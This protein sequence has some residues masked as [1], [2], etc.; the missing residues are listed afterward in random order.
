M[1]QPLAALEAKMAGTDL[2]GCS[3]AELRA[4][5]AEADAGLRV[6][7]GYQARI[8][9]AA[10]QLE[11]QGRGS[12]AEDTMRTGTVS[13][14]M[15]RRLADRAAIG[16]LLPAVGA[17]LAAGA[18]RPENVD[19]LAAKTRHLSDRERRRLVDRDAVLARQSARLAPDTFSRVVAK[20]VRAARDPE[21]EGLSVVE[22]QA[23]RSRFDM[24]RAFDGMWDLR[25][26]LDDERGQQLNDWINQHAPA[27]RPTSDH[28]SVN[29][30]AAALHDLTAR[31][32]TGHPGGEVVEGGGAVVD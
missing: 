6:I 21:P 31:G 20:E 32:A 7:A 28:V 3:S 25:G 11:R 26:Q 24:S 13:P 17:G 14:K 18:V 2:G 9:A 19:I 15:A 12:T 5:S 30:R 29:D 10:R 4:L 16:E 8:A 22:R 27:L 1:K 23:R